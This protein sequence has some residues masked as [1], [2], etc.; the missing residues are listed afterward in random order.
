MSL[1]SRR[2]WHEVVAADAP[3]QLG[4]GAYSGRPART[5]PWIDGAWAKGA[6]AGWAHGGCGAWLA[7]VLVNAISAVPSAFA[8]AR[9]SEAVSTSLVP[10]EDQD[11]K[12]TL[13]P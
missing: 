3:I 2:H 5:S 8:A 9:S 12:E 11:G 6:T 10:S 1:P 13:K 4:C 7:G